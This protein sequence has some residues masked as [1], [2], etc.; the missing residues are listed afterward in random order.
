[1]NATAR[2]VVSEVVREAAMRNKKEFDKLE[3]RRALGS[4]PTGVTIIS[5]RSSEGR[6]VGVTCSSFNSVSLDPPLVLW[7]L[8]KNSYSRAVFETTPNWA[9]NLLSSDQ[10]A[11]SNQCARAGNDKF[12]GIET[13]EGIA[14]VPLLT[15]CCARFQCATEFVY[16]GGDHLILVGRV[17]AFDRSDR[18]P[19]VF[20]SGQYN[21][22]IADA[23]AR[24]LG[25]RTRHLLDWA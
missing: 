20:H 18:L 16:E 3:F 4:F 24:A 25:M 11:H 23:V 9:V 12:A 7:S 19:L 14:G 22:Q 5:A 2:I 17:L 10:E 8:A 15:G 1:M 21:R 6:P 13:E